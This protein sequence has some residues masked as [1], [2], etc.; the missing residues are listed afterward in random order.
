M[1]P[2]L[3]EEEEEDQIFR[4]TPYRDEPEPHQTADFI[5]PPPLPLSPDHHAETFSTPSGE[6][7]ISF[8]E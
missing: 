8:A 1:Q 3:T 2:I 4:Q 5:P 6:F 7:V